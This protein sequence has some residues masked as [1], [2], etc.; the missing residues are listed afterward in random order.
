MA[1][2]NNMNI[3]TQTEVNINYID[4]PLAFFISNKV[5]CMREVD[6]ILI[7]KDFYDEKEITDAKD[8]VFK[9]YKLEDEIIIRKG[10]NKVTSDLQDIIRLVRNK[11]ALD[12]IKF[13]I[14]SCTRVPPVALDHIDAA[15]LVK[16]VS[17]L[18]LD[19]I[20]LKSLSSG[21]E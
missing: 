13:C 17:E 11:P 4:S 2:E 16:S 21:F 20:K 8:L 7:C 9:T 5:D 1:K 18:R 12:H 3:Q 14:T 15:A 19:I 10:A 6:I